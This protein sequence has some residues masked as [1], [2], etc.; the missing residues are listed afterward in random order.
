VD[1]RANGRV[2]AG[3]VA[4]TREQSDAFRHVFLA[5]AGG[6]GPWPAG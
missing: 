5:L 3:A 2:E 1:D 4:P 6:F